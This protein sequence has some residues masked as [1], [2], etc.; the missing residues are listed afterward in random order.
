MT[1]VQ[2]KTIKVLLDKCSER[3]ISGV[4]VEDKDGVFTLYRDGKVDVSGSYE[5]VVS[6][7]NNL[8]EGLG[9]VQEKLGKA[10]GKEMAEKLK[11]KYPEKK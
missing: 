3:G 1:Y 9:I 8:A 5:K 6:F 11:K 2:R 4:R 7:L 10:K